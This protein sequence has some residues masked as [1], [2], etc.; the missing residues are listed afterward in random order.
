MKLGRR[1]I[2]AWLW[3]LVAVVGGIA[4]VLTSEAMLLSIVGILA[5][6]LGLISL[7]PALLFTLEDEEESIV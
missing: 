2:V 7:M 4:I 5:I 6:I 1:A 3:V